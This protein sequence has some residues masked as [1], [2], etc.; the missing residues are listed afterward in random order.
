MPIDENRSFF[1]LV[2]RLGTE[3]FEAALRGDGPDGTPLLPGTQPIRR[4]PHG[5]RWDSR[6]PSECVV[7]TG[8]RAGWP[9]FGWGWSFW[10]ERYGDDPVMSKQRAPVFDSDTWAETVC[11]RASATG[12][13][14]RARAFC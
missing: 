14:T 7:L 3:A 5:A 1:D 6:F 9:G 11:H 2:E 13:R 12:A 8:E 10:E 4:I